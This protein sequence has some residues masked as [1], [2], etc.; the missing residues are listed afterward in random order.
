MRDAIFSG[1]HAK[2]REGLPLDGRWARLRACL[3]GRNLRRRGPQAVVIGLGANG[4]GVVRA[5][6]R[7]R[8]QVV[9][10][11]T[12]AGEVGRHSRHCRALRLPDPDRD[13]GAFLKDL[14]ALGERLGDRPALFWTV[15]SH[16]ALISRERESLGRLFRFHLPAQGV[17]DR[18]MDKS[19]VLEAA[20][21][22]GIA[23]PQS[24]TFPDRAQLVRGLD[25][26]SL[27]C[28]A[29][30]R[31]PW[32]RR[33]AG[34][35]KVALLATREELWRFIE[36]YQPAAEELVIQQLIEGGDADHAFC[37]LYVDSSS[38]VA[39]V[40]TGRTIHRYP[41]GLGMTA[42]CITLEIRELEEAGERLL[43]GEGYRGL[44]E[45]EFKKDRRDGA[46]KLF[47]VNTRPWAYNALAPACGANLVYLAYLDAIGERWSGERLRGRP[48][49][50]WMNAEYEAGF[51]LRRLQRGRLS[52]LPWCTFLPGT[53]RAFFA[54]DDPRPALERLLWRLRKGWT[55]RGSGRARRGSPAGAL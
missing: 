16:L 42:S 40:V 21:R 47:E 22:Y 53:T 36:R 17:L 52:A 30:P 8:V 2:A 45:L 12:E 6:A 13:P 37:L 9:G 48:G 32:R 31:L 1:V 34:L 26:L 24:V 10:I 39:G 41:P 33:E 50:A 28:V 5:L 27:P 54:W 44:A 29:K 23:A 46:Y 7:M 15:D 49:H 25:S 20:R 35:P 18:L 11:Y 43:L 38:R 14:L 51:F 55:R 3:G 19:A 4:L